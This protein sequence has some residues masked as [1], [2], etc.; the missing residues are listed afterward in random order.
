[1]MRRG[2]FRLSLTFL[3]D[4]FRGFSV[5]FPEELFKTLA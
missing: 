1:M 5:S 2:I 4:F 3:E